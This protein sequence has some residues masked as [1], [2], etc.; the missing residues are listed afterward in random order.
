MRAFF[1][2]ELDGA[3]RAAL[4]ALIDRLRQS[5]ARASWVKPPALHLTLRFL[6]EV[7]EDD[8]Q[9]AADVMAKEVQGT[10][11]FTCHIRGTGAFPSVRR[12]SVVWAG[13]EPAESPLLDVQAASE[14]AAQAIQLP[15]ERKPF[16]PH[17]T[18]ARIREP[19]RAEPLIPLLQREG[20]FDGGAITVQH[21][22]LF[23]SR[24]TPQGAV[25]TAVREVAF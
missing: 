3:A 14:R 23:S 12:P 7:N 25:Y 21:V 9:R 17:I 13:V 4:T 19:R 24:L 1:A 8:A 16:H 5:G 15:P 2:I 11:P 6:G 10:P 20:S 22:T 18:L